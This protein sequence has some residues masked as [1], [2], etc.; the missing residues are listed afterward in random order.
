M[1]DIRLPHMGLLHT[2]RQL[3]SIQKEFVNIWLV[4]QLDL[5]F[6]CFMYKSYIIHFCIMTI[7]I[8]IILG[9]KL[10]YMH[11]YTHVHTHSQAHAHVKKKEEKKRCIKNKL[12]KKSNRWWKKSIKLI[13]S[14]RL[15]GFSVLKSVRLL[16]YK[17][18]QAS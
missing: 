3:Y 14:V 11:A 2:E 16:K 1:W 18:I 13:F 12:Y 15:L 17:M 5:L 9:K 7:S 4:T 8:L 6:K 10:Q